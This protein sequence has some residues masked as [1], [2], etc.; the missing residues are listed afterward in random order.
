MKLSLVAALAFALT[1]P[2]VAHADDAPAPTPAPAPSA[3][4]CVDGRFGDHVEKG[5]AE[6]DAKAIVAAN[7]AVYSV[8]VANTGDAAQ[9]TLVWSVDGKEVQRQSLD[10]GHAPHWRTWGWRPVGHAKSIEVRVLDAAGAELRK[11]SLDLTAS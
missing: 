1:L 6:G 8:D 4:T 2:A 7:K 9:V 3:V 11:D 5:H 10:V